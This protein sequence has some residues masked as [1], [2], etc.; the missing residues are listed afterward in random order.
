MNITSLSAI[1]LAIMGLCLIIRG[2]I[3]GRP[4]ERWV[5]YAC[6]LLLLIVGGVAYQLTGPA[7]V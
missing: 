2:K 7:P 4:G 1:A 3:Q 5:W 6:G